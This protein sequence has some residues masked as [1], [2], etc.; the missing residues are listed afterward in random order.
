MDLCDCVN[1]HPQQ[2][3][4]TS[5]RT[6][7]INFQEQTDKV[8]QESAH[9]GKI[10]KEPRANLYITM[11]RHHEEE[12]QRRRRTTS[13]NLTTMRNGSTSASAS[14]ESNSW[15]TNDGT[16]TSEAQT[17]ATSTS[18]PPTAQPPQQHA[19][20]PLI[21]VKLKH[22][23]TKVVEKA[24]DSFGYYVGIE[25]IWHVGLFATCYRYRPLVYISKN[26]KYG[27]MIVEKIQQQMHS[28]M[29]PSSSS[30]STSS[31]TTTSRLQS[32]LGQLSSSGKNHQRTLVAISEWFFFN[33][34][35]GIPLW[36][37]KVALA[38]YLH[39][40]FHDNGTTKDD[41]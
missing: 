15:T 38:S 23:V 24:S 30:S 25:A 37:T 7:T 35:I 26:T 8:K 27:K 40:K 34:V 29:S 17:S 5:V 18:T 20:Q 1:K 4:G 28:R 36:P 9:K 31:S 32:I 22:Q 14:N 16:S 2:E 3:P 41:K 11:E 12:Q 6:L 10:T 19:K 39:S 21:P 13:F 33:K